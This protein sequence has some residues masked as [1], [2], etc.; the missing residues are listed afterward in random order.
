MKITWI[1][2][3]L[4][5][6]HA[7]SAQS[8]YLFFPLSLDEGLSDARVNS[9]MQDRYGFMWFGTSNGLNRYDG[10]SVK[11]YY[12]D[13]RNGLPGN[14]IYT[15]FSD[16]KGLLWIG[17]SR[18]AVR[19]NFVTQQFEP[20]S[21]Q[22]LPATAVYCFTEDARG[23]VYI[24]TK[25]GL[26]SWS[27]ATGNLENVSKKLG[28]PDR[29]TLIKGLLC[30]DNELLFA[31]TE[32]KGFYQLNIRTMQLDSFRF[33]IKDSEEGHPSMFG[34]ERINNHELLVGSLSF[35]V[36]RFDRRT[37]TFSN[38]KGM[39]RKREG[40]LFNT[41]SQIRKDH[42]G[43]FWVTSNYFRLGEYL[44]AYDSVA[45]TQ[46]ESDSPYGFEDHNANCVYE[47]RQH[48]IWIGT[49]L[50]G[51]YR[52]NPNRKRVRFYSANDLVAGALQ[53]GKV[54]SIA[55]LDSNTLMIGTH[56]GP[57]IYTRS[58][59][60]FLN[61]KG[62]AYNFG[63]KALESVTAGLKDRYGKIWMG[64][65]R[66]GLMRYDPVSGQISVFGRFTQPHPFQDDGISD[67][68]ET[69]GDSLLVIGYSRPAVF[70]TRNFTSRSFRHD[71]ITPLYQV[72]NAVDLCY[73]HQRKYIWLAT[74]SCELFMFDPERQQLSNRSDLLRG[75]E[76]LTTIYGIA[77]DP[78][79]RLWC[80]T[81][82]GAVCLQSGK[83]HQAY[84][85]GER[86][87]SFTEVKNILPAG[88]YVWLTNN[89]TVARLHTTTGRM[90]I[91][92]EKD[93][94][95]GVQLY[96]RS[97]CLSPW[98]T[99][100]IGGNH[101][102]YEIF[103][104]QITDEPISSSAC[105]T[106]FRVYDRPFA[107]KEMVST[108][109]E[110]RL[111]YRQNFFSFDISA[112]DYSE[113]DEIEYAYKLEGF[114][115][116][117]V[118]IGRQRTGSY[119]NVPGGDYLLRLKVRNSNG[120]WNE[121]GQQIRIHINK[122]FWETGWFLALAILLT[123]AV[124]YLVYS[125]RVN[126][127]RR[128][129]RLRSDYEIKLNELENSALRT[130][131]NPHFIFNSLN[132]I[133][134]FINSNER[135]RANQYISKFSRLIRLI[136][137][138]SREKKIS[139]TNELEVVNLYV[140]LEQIRFEYKFNYEISIGEG[141]TTD[142]LEVP[143]LIIQPFVEN[144]ILHGLL[145]LASGGLLHIKVYRNDG[146]LLLLIED[147][148]IGRQQAKKHK[149]PAQEKHKSHGIDITLKRIELFNK[150]HHF[151]GRVTLID[152]K[153]EAG[154]AAGTRVEIPLAWEESF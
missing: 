40:I 44:P 148:G 89:R 105:L 70:N 74:G 66:L 81:N 133:N 63:N 142:D 82:I 138:H 129:A 78:A 80:A 120:I 132:T 30:L 127:V 140:Q 149:L 79:G 12:S 55:A 107:T 20:V 65:S 53:K 144:A 123:G 29:L 46:P 92:G 26:F 147:N 62:H 68:L 135:E 95:D 69:K 94:F 15:L 88:E 106:A 145:P 73:D 22:P 25:D 130:Q 113:A 42:A 6:F 154:N 146:H 5:C 103:P 3:L 91:L 139:L 35:G 48:N 33:K 86:S 23:N 97:L 37:G 57:S 71:S 93:G 153:E 16:S 110:I 56:N 124:I 151:E 134:S 117:W 7:G 50:N 141:I 104:E 118:Y 51:L 108:V 2:V 13:K 1:V 115:K 101:G 116:D 36:L 11:T 96:G 137:D 43:R 77:F 83:A 18:G 119:T 31:S 38:P 98:N 58:T 52:F 87:G 24:G 99:V 28:V 125:Y 114:D 60:R 152:L 54:F 143:P 112:F 102:F 17:T 34:M 85:I 4:L 84:T 109:K 90:V 41:V 64:S 128:Q 100:L 150:E 14:N 32:K 67:M 47:D 75:I 19:F 21:K 121:Q 45:L 131:M 76:R 59:N 111:S 8:D 49:A 72:K 9:I 136:L 39:L 61:F 10:Y 126:S 122:P 27:R